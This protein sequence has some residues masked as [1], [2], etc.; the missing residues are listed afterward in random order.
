M[1][2]AQES[3]GCHAARKH[4]FTELRSPMSMAGHRAAKRRR[5]E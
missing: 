3:V 5:L 4:P 1:D 2:S